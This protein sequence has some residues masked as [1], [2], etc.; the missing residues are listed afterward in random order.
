M[1]RPVRR[2]LAAGVAIAAGVVALARASRDRPLPHDGIRGR[3]RDLAAHDGTRLHVRYTGVPTADT[4]VVMVHGWAMGLSF[5]RE[6]AIDLSADHLV[7]RYDQRG[8]GSS[9]DPGPAGA[10]LEAIGADLADVLGSI[11]GDRP[12]VVVGHSMGAMSVVSWAAQHA[13]DRVVGAVLFNTGM[14]DLVPASAATWG[15]VAT[16]AEPVLRTVMTTAAPL[17]IIPEA[18]MR[19][20]VAYAAHGPAADDRAIERT[21]Q[22]VRRSRPEVRSAF[23]RSMAA[24][25]LRPALASLRIPTLVVAGSHDR[26]TPVSLAEA[27]VEGLPDGCLEVVDDTGHQMPLERPEVAAG[28][29]RAHAARVVSDGQSAA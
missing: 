3:R 12:I 17:G 14:H 11:R 19:S 27:L 21:T 16:P 22:L 24:M 26:M 20:V 1:A 4:V 28:V 25:D 10:T 18:A 6:T 23:G 29:V 2:R 13:D 15:R 5:W 7:V 8:H 9:D